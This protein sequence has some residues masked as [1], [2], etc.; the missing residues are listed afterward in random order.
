MKA[1]LAASQCPLCGHLFELRDGFGEMLPLAHCADCDSYYPA[2]LG[3]CRWCGTAPEGFRFA[4]YALKGVGVLAFAGLVSAAWIASRSDEEAPPAEL[5]SVPNETSS[6]VIT[7]RVDSGV[8]FQAPVF[9]G[10]EDTASDFTPTP[11][12]VGIETPNASTDAAPPPY[13]GPGTDATE[14]A[15]PSLLGAAEVVAPR[16]VVPKKTP[17]RSA[18]SVRW[19][20]ATAR[21]WVTVRASPTHGSR[22]LASVGPDTRVQ[23]GEARG[24][25]RRIRMKGLSGWVERAKF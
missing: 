13:Q 7:T 17:V 11:V 1:M 23:L 12:P 8:D 22:I 10:I 3:T 5:V 24:D 21:R 14:P 20:G 25:W 16:A 6:A 4:P 2:R 19:I 15:P 9:A 18:R